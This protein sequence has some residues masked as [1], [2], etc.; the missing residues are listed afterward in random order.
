MLQAKEMAT[1]NVVLPE[2]LFI[3]YNDTG[4]NG[5]PIKAVSTTFKSHVGNGTLTGENNNW[6]RQKPKLNDYQQADA[7]LI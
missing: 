1:K 5:K 6:A 2:R 3:G 4:S 7:M